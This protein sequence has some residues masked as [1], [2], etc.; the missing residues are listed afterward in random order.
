MEFTDSADFSILENTKLVGC[1]AGGTWS[2][3]A[4]YFGCFKGSMLKEYWDY[5]NGVLISNIPSEATVVSPIILV[6]K[7]QT[8]NNLLFKPMLTTDLSATYGDYVRYSGDGELNKNVSEIY[9]TLKN[10]EIRG[11]NNLFDIKCAEIDVKEVRYVNGSFENVA[12]DTKELFYFQCGFYNDT[13]SLGYG[14]TKIINTIGIHSLT[15]TVPTNATRIRLK[16]NGAKQDITFCWVRLSD[17]G[18]TAGDPITI[19]IK[20]NKI[21]PRVQYGI[22][23][24]DMQIE[25]SI[26][27]SEYTPNYKSISVLNENVAALFDKVEEHET[28][29][30]SAETTIG[31]HTSTLATHTSQ[32][33]Q[34][35]ADLSVSYVSLANGVTLT[36]CGNQRIIDFSDI[37][38]AI[39]K[40]LPQLSVGDRPHHSIFTTGLR[41]SSGAFGCIATI[42]IDTN[43][44]IIFR[45]VSYYNNGQAFST[46]DDYD[47]QLAGQIVWYV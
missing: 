36:R 44:N 28:R 21:N 12:T 29:L 14:P 47:G 23:I 40:S 17:L 22:Q 32:I 45:F 11:S 24:T 2:T 41:H 16:H 19:S 8:V 6:R 18:L 31:N 13:E 46:F 27:A 5:G 42:K 20:A 30:D 3:Y 26:T 33:A 9:N 15:S 4:M 39:I 38:D 37:N 10:V 25:K 35:N 1:P 43:G 34:I 7:G